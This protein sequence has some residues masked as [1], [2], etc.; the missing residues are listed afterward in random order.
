MQK[1]I[2]LLIGSELRNKFILFFIVLASVPT[3]IL[4]AVSLYLIDSSHRYDV[5]NLEL[6]LIDQKI[7]EIR[8]FF[9]D[10]LGII[11]LRVGFTQKSEIEYSQQIFLLDG[12]LEENRALDEVSFID[13]RGQETAKKSRFRDFGEF[14][15][16]SNLD[17]FKIPSRGENFISDVYYTLSGPSVTL[18]SPVRNRS[19]DII[20]I[21]TAEVNLSQIT[22][23]LEQSRLGSSGYLVLLDRDG[24]LITHQGKQNFQ[25][26]ADLSGTSRIK[27]VLGG[28]VLDA[29]GSED[30]Y[31]SFLGG[32]EVV[33]AAKRIPQIG[34][35]LMVE[36]PINDADAVIRDVRSQVGRLAIFGI[37]AVLILAPL[38]AI[39]LIKPIKILEDSAKEIE[40]GNFDKKVEIKTSDEL[41]QLGEAF[42]KMAKG[43]KRLQE[44]KNEFVFI[45]AHELRTPVTAIRGYLS[46]V[47]DDE[48]ASLSDKVKKY[49]SIVSQSNERLIQLV[50]DILEIA[51]S[52]AGRMQIQVSS[53]DIKESVRAIL[54]EVKPLADTKKINIIYDDKISSSL[55]LA[56]PAR[57]KE[58]IMNFVS[59]AIKYNNDGGWVKVY[60]EAKD[61]MIL[62]HVEDNGFGMSQE[63]QQH[64][65]EKFFRADTGKIKA[66][67]GTGL[68][69]F[70]TRELVEK[71]NG[72]VWLKSEEGKGTTFSFS[73]PISPGS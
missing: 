67:Q 30:R 35:V 28:E 72:K 61:N 31:Q 54:A 15:N 64:M 42:N 40:K 36:W 19:N 66:I 63:E 4:G 58:V 25:P 24:V 38:F 49:L 33:G 2:Q 32:L 45:A 21:L 6:Q 29:L 17:K 59:N 69:L 44:L 22:K 16:V 11:E 52:E 1:F 47:F 13:L 7:E 8:K 27:R 73:L 70:I 50:N 34:W 55:I 41:E 5:S 39:R 23:S 62:T 71:M 26:G 12:L 53:T 9:A 3:I 37:F 48:A 46:M 10:T 51:R 65:F 68:G 14:F 20:Q 43:L 56:D 60:H 18:A 57:L